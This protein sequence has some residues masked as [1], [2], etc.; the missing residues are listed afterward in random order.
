MRSPSFCTLSSAVVQLIS[1]IG[2]DGGIGTFVVGR[3]L[4]DTGLFKR[5]GAAAGRQP[6]VSK[7]GKK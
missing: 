7:K 1:P 3:S 5:A 4:I 6:L 2:F